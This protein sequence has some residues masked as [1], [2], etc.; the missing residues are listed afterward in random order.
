MADTWTPAAIRRT[1]RWMAPLYDHWFRRAYEGM[2]RESLAGP[3]V[4]PGG[5]VLAIGVGTG[6][7][8]PLLPPVGRILAADLSPSMLRRAARKPVSSPVDVFVA[9]GARLPLPERSVSAAILHLVLCSAP[10]GRA[11]LAETARVLEAGGEVAILDHFAPHGAMR[12]WRRLGS[13]FAWVLGT[14]IDR[15]FQPMVEGL[16]FEVLRDKPVAGGLYRIIRLRRL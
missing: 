16:P 7:D 8:L 10:D 5:T 13:R 3:G 2:R 12:R 4:Q 15:R 14:R 11:L 6:L 1:Y 9:D